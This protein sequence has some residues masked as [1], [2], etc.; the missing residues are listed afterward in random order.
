MTMVRVD[1]VELAKSGKSHNVFAGG[2]W[3]T[4]KAPGIEQALGKTIDATFGS[5][6]L[7]GMSD[8]RA[9]I[10]SFSYAENAPAGKAPQPDLPDRWWL[11]F[12]SNQVAHAQLAGQIK[13]EE[14]AK[15]W[16]EIFYR[17]IQGVDRDAFP[18]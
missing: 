10:D 8:E 5:F 4:C 9:T 3:Y 1:K 14:D 12:V 16:A 18:F 15:K 13:S 6:K 11:S 17:V 7:P 2:K